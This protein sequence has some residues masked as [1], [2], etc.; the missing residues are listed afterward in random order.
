MLQQ[1]CCPVFVQ[2]LTSAL[3]ASCWAFH[4]PDSTC[5]ELWLPSSLCITC[6]Q[7]FG[8]AED[9]AEE[10]PA[11]MKPA[12]A[13]VKRTRAAAKHAG[14]PAAFIIV[15]VCVVHT[16]VHTLTGIYSICQQI[17][18][19]LSTYIHTYL[20]SICQQRLSS[21]SDHTVLR[22][23]CR[24]FMLIFQYCI[25]ILLQQQ[26]LACAN[27]DYLVGH[28]PTRWTVNRFSARLTSC[29]SMQQICLGFGNARR[30]L[31]HYRLSTCAKLHGFA[32]EEEGLD[33]DEA[34]ARRL[35]EQEDALATRGRAT[36]G[37]LRVTLKP[38]LAAQKGPIRG[39]ES[40]AV[41]SSSR[42]K[43][44]AAESKEGPTTRGMGS[45]GVHP[46]PIW[47][48]SQQIA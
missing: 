23:T 4:R 34:L 20:Y 24:A 13:G 11:A 27:A 15:Y 46:K 19:Y 43:P 31:L 40:R 47:T 42:L 17:H 5:G 18:I 26:S 39:S 6:K 33:D 41:R 25:C 36:R 30:S 29:G 10:E 8:G 32:G 1:G 38:K 9:S 2:Y 3:H 14:Q 16:Y 48:M 12:R 45:A 44:Q 37:A 22:H 28:E 35:Q 21:A 7:L